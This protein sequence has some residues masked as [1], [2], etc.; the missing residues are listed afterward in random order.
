MTLLALVLARVPA[1]ASDATPV[2]VGLYPS[3]PPLDMRDPRTDELQG[4]D[5]DLGQ[6]LARRM[7]RTPRIVETSFAQLIP[8]LL[9]GRIAMFF[10]GMMDTPARRNSIA[11]VD[12]LQSGLQFIILASDDHAPRTPADLCGRMVG[13][14]RITSE[15]A[16][17]IAWSDQNCV[18]EHRPP[19]RLF[20]TE[21]S[22]DARLQLREGRVVAVLQDSL[23]APWTAHA[24]GGLFL[25]LGDPFDMTP[26]GIGL[27]KDDVALACRTATALAAL[28]TD[29]T[30]AA[31]IRKWQLPPSSAI[32]T[33]RPKDC[34]LPTD[35]D[36]P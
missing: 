22:A 25:L 12:Y 32:T 7:G 33:A 36:R 19:V 21:N 6:M 18:R 2:T 3:Y 34:P 10:N 1:C 13:A 4:F 23:T 11:F 14:S 16:S 24:T 27:P 17:L 28:Q 8:S 35:C 5:V 26:L 29:G 9:T 30:Y 15:P 31:L 20:A